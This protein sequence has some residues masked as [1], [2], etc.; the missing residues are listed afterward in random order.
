MAGSQ[1]GWEMGESPQMEEWL[2]LIMVTARMKKLR[3][4]SPA[5]PSTPD[6]VDLRAVTRTQAISGWAVVSR[7]S[8]L[9]GRQ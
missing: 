9:D 2:I 4:K 1:K 6:R 8:V 3:A 7:A 5:I